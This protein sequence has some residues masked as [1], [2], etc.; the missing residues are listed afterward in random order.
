MISALILFMDTFFY[1]LF[2]LNYYLLLPLDSLFSYEDNLVL[3]RKQRQ[4]NTN[5]Q[6]VSVKF[7]FL[8]EPTFFLNFI[9]TNPDQKNNNN[10]YRSQKVLRVISVNFHYLSVLQEKSGKYS[11]LETN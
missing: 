9:S 5:G 6:E 10:L 2:M 7:I 8:K 11:N 1:L 3:S 4:R